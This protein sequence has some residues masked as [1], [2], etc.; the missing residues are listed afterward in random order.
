VLF[1]EIMHFLLLSM[2]RGRYLVGM[3]GEI[4][5]SFYFFPISLFCFAVE[6]ERVFQVAPFAFCLLR[7]AEKKDEY[8]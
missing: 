2:L 1:I 4:L 7:S 6:R 3:I 8:I 5:F